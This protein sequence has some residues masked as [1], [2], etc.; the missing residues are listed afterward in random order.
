MSQPVWDQGVPVP[1]MSSHNRVSLSVVPEIIA[2]F[3]ASGEQV[4]QF[5]CRRQNCTEE[6]SGELFATLTESR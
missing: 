1:L 2:D 3:P 4:V 6:S 5:V